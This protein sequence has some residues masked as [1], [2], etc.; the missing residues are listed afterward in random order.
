MHIVV[1]FA[2][3]QLGHFPC[4]DL[5]PRITLLKCNKYAFSLSMCD[6]ILVCGEQTGHDQTETRLTYG[7]WSSYIT[8]F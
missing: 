8:R 5:C 4:Y 3:G 1:I 2:K 7:E 6:V